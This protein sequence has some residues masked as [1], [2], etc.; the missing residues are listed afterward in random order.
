LTPQPHCW[1]RTTHHFA[2]GEDRYGTTVAAALWPVPHIDV[3]LHVR[4]FLD[5]LMDEMF[6]PLTPAT[7]HV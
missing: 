1:E 7:I 6:H 5:D 3:H 4:Q 2:E